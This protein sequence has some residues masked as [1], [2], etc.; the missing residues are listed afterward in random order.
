[1]LSSR[2]SILSRLETIL[3]R[4]QTSK[5]SISSITHTVSMR[6]HWKYV[7]A[8]TEVS[9]T[10]LYTFKDPSI[11]K[12][13]EV[14]WMLFWSTVLLASDLED[15]AEDVDLPDDL[16]ILLK[17]SSRTSAPLLTPA[18][19]SDSI[20]PWT[21]ENEEICQPVWNNLQ[22]RVLDELNL[23]H[24]NKVTFILAQRCYSSRILWKQS[25]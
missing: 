4:H 21:H 8:E 22:Q 10:S 9:M 11:L 12:E 13:S 23:C 7:N 25:Y 1:M 2:S 3:K 6:I 20:F 17:F 15:C 14:F 18:Q 24:D 19:V 5:L 16:S